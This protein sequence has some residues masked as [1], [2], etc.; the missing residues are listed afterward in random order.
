MAACEAVELVSNRRAQIKWVNDIYL[1]DR[2]ISGILTEASVSMETG[3]V[4][5]VILGLE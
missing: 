5:Y 2:K 3:S 1:D 4:E